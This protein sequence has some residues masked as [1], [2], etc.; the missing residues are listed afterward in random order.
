MDKSFTAALTLMAA[1][2]TYGG[3]SMSHEDV[4][5]LWLAMVFTGG[6]FT[7]LLLLH[8]LKVDVTTQQ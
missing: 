3:L 5:Y 4:G 6:F 2:M 8:I 1:G 7:S